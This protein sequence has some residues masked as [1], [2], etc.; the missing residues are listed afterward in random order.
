MT[1]E[2][3]GII[4]SR[5]KTPKDTEHNRQKYRG[6]EIRRAV[7]E[8]CGETYGSFNAAWDNYNT[9]LGLQLGMDKIWG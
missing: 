6:N 5:G 7:W 4:F 3:R 8:S 1:W 2:E 9:A